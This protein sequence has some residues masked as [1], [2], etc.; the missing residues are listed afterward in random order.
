MVLDAN[1]KY[2]YL[3]DAP[4]IEGTSEYIKGATNPE[5][6]VKADDVDKFIALECIPMNKEG[7]QGKL[8][9]VF[10]ND[11]KKITDAPGIEGT[12]EYIKGKS[13]KTQHCHELTE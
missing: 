13:F 1:M 3:K 10:A 12:S 6:A 8:V 4:G 9:R 11:Q 2:F 5:Y 7:R